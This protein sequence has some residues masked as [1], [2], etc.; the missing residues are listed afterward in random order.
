MTYISSP[1]LRT[2]TSSGNAVFKLQVDNTSGSGTTITDGTLW[3]KVASVSGGTFSSNGTV[4]IREGSINGSIVHSFT[5]F[6]GVSETNWSNYTL[7]FS[8]GSRTYY[9]TRNGSPTSQI[10]S[11]G[12]TVTASP[13]TATLSNI[14]TS[15]ASGPVGT[16]MTWSYTVSANQGGNVL[17]GAQL[18]S[19]GGTNYDIGTGYAKTL[20][21]G[22][23]SYSISISVPSGVPDGTYSL[24]GAVWRDNDSD[25]VINAGVDTILSGPSAYN[26]FTV[27]SPLTVTLSN[28]TTSPASGLPGTAMT[29]TYSVQSNQSK[30]VLLG[31][32]LQSSG[33]TNYDIGTGY[34]RS[35][36]SG[37][38]SPTVSLTVPAGIPAGTYSLR[39][40]VWNDNN[41]SGSID[42]GDTLLSGAFNYGSFTVTSPLTVTLSNI[43]TSPASGPV[44]TAMTW[45]YT[46]SANQG[47]NVLLGAQL[48][49][50]GGTNYD[51][52]TGYAKTLSAG[53]GSY[54][55]SI[56]VPSGVPDGTYSLRGAVW[57]DNDS[58][59]VINAGVDTILS[60][61]SAYNSF[62]VTSPPVITGFSG[63]MRSDGR[64]DFKYTATNANGIGYVAVYIMNSDQSVNP[65]FT[66]ASEVQYTTG[67]SSGAA[68]TL[69]P[70]SASQL[71]GWLT[72]GTLYR[73]RMKAQ[74][75][76]GSDSGWVYSTTFLYTE[77]ASAPVVQTPMVAAR[78]DGRLDVTTQAT[79]S[80]GL[81]YLAFYLVDASMA[82]NPAFSAASKIEETTGLTSGLSQIRQP[83]TAS[84]LA[85]WLTPGSQYRVRIKYQ[86]TRA[87]DSGWVYS[88][89]FTYAGTTNA[90]PTVASVTATVLLDGSLKVGFTATDDMTASLGIEVYL[91]MPGGAGDPGSYNLSSKVVLAAA[92]GTEKSYTYLPAEVTRLCS[93]GQ[94]HG[95]RVRAF[96]GSGAM[97]QGFSTVFAAPQSATTTKDV[98]SFPFGNRQNYTTVRDNDGWY[99]SQTFGTYNAGFGGYHLGEDWNLESGGNTDLGQPVFAIGDGTVVVA[100][101][102]TGWGNIVTIRHTLA[103]GLQVESFYAHLDRM[104]VAPGQV[105]SRGQQIGTVGDGGGTQEASHLH[106]ELRENTGSGWPAIGTGYSATARPAGWLDPGTFIRARLPGTTGVQYSLYRVSDTSG[107][108]H[109]SNPGQSRSL[110]T[111]GQVV[112]LTFLARN[113]GASTPTYALCNVRDGQTETT[114][115]RSPKNNE[116]GSDAAIGGGVAVSAATLLGAGQNMY[117]SFDVDT[118]ALSAGGYDVSGRLWGG[119]SGPS[120]DSTSEGIGDFL[121]DSW[122]KND[123]FI[124]TTGA[125]TSGDIQGVDVSR[126]NG[127]INW[128]QLAAEGVSFAYIR[129]SLGTNIPDT[130]YV[131]NAAGA[132]A[133]GIVHGA[134]HFAYPAINAA[135]AEASYF[136]RTARSQ[137]GA[138][139]LPPA[140]D[141]ENQSDVALT[142]SL[143][144]AALTDW[145]LAF[146]R[147]V[148]RQTGVKPIV[149][150]N[151]NFATNEV[152]SRV[153]E[154]PLWVADY[155]PN[156]GR[157]MLSRSPA[158]G[159]WPSWSL[160][161]FTSRATLTGN[162]ST[163][164][165]RNHFPGDQTAFMSFIGNSTVV[166]PPG[167]V[168][169]TPGSATLPGEALA[170]LTPRFTWGAAS[171]ATGYELTVIN[172]QANLEVYK[173]GTIG[174]TTTFDLPAGTLVQG[175]TYF[176]QMRARRG[177]LWSLSSAPLYFSTGGNVSPPVK[178]IL[179]SPTGATLPGS[180]VTSL[181]PTLTWKAQSTAMQHRLQI[182][183]TA[184]GESVFDNERLGNISSFQVPAGTL[185]EAKVYLWKVTA[186]NAAGWGP[187]SAPSYFTTPPGS[188]STPVPPVLLSPGS[189]RSPYPVLTSLTPTLTWQD[190]GFAESYAIIVND[191]D[192][193]ARAYED[194][195]LAPTTNLSLPAG[196]LLP[197]KT[198]HWSLRYRVGGL[199]STWAAA[200]H[201]QTKADLSAPAITSLPM[202][203]LIGSTASQSLTVLGT[204][205]QKGATVLL[206]N[207]TLSDQPLAPSKVV[208][209]DTT[210][211]TASL[212]TGTSADA[213]II[214]VRN[215]DGKVSN[216]ATFSVEAP[217][218]PL[219]AA[220]DIYPQ[221][222]K[223]SSPVLVTLSHPD[224]GVTL[225]YTTDGSVPQLSST[226][227][228]TP[229]LLGNTNV[230][231]RVRAFKDGARPSQASQVYTFDLPSQALNT[232]VIGKSAGSE[233]Y[234]F[235]IPIGSTTS[236]VNI[237]TSGGT[238][239]CSMYVGFNRLPTVTDYDRISPLNAGNEESITIQNPPLGKLYVMLI[240]SP[241]FSGL[242]VS[243]NGATTTSKA[244]KPRFNFDP[245]LHRAPIQNLLI[246]TDEANATIYYTI[247]SNAPDPTP[248]NATALA[249]GQS[250]PIFFTT[251]VRARSVVQGKQPSDLLDGTFIIINKGDPE[252]AFL[253][254]THSRKLA[255]SVE[256]E[257]DTPLGVADQLPFFFDVP[258]DGAFA[259]N[260]RIKFA[261]AMKMK[262][263]GQYTSAD[264]YFKRSTAPTTTD[265][266]YRLSGLSNEPLGL[267]KLNL[268]KV[269]PS[270]PGI[271]RETLVPGARYYGLLVAQGG[272]PKGGAIQLPSYKMKLKVELMQGELLTPQ[273]SD[274][275]AGKPNTWLAIH[276]RADE[277]SN[278][279]NTPVLRLAAALEY[280]P[281][282]VRS[283]VIMLDWNS[284][285]ADSYDLLQ[286]YKFLSAAVY[287]H[288][289]SSRV[290]DIFIANGMPPKTLSITGH[291]WGTFVAF[292]M[293]SPT[294]KLKRLIALDPAAAGQG[295]FK[296]S[297]VNFSSVAEKSWAFVANGARVS[298]AANPL[299]FI[300]DSVAEGLAGSPAKAATAREAFVIRDSDFTI[301]D[302]GSAYDYLI[303]MHSAPV[304]FFTHTLMRNYGLGTSS[305]VISDYF[306]I[307]KLDNQ[308]VKGDFPWLPN[309]MGSEIGLQQFEGEISA[310][311]EAANGIDTTQGMSLRYVPRGQSTDQTFLQQP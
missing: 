250:I 205:F 281:T 73:L 214:K 93:P 104:D 36:A 173:N 33:G 129:S 289:V 105:V 304:G 193:G 272:N 215:P 106:L 248:H 143:S 1:A 87:T 47:G 189:V 239:D 278:G 40:A 200:F 175:Q 32:A 163:Y 228:T 195:N 116:V 52:G 111:Q 243:V 178:T 99:A 69:Q 147:E 44:G 231:L 114:V 308:T 72:S 251:R 300:R 152:D 160:W 146:C 168:L 102:Y 141:V 230:T 292:K 7:P 101:S 246:N 169:K 71:S 161:Q 39:G 306:S 97:G 179:V 190:L 131:T 209:Q 211:L 277:V 153:S 192:T 259:G 275:Q 229:I 290:K 136:V 258:A 134:Y 120:L 265:Y 156:D 113:T 207:S 12:V 38:N 261:V 186:W 273:G 125:A 268:G 85:S 67:L 2:Y 122:W 140:L 255:G 112:R 91:S 174:N 302:F 287:I 142:S 144:S 221:G 305:D 90:A 232:T 238:G 37:S 196:R 4:E 299:E 263:E 65:A 288:A 240:G 50:S 191:S 84:S 108:P 282:T 66:M 151:R 284:M 187:A 79:D 16:A 49:S 59:G 269:N 109:S 181:T 241:P 118:S 210:R 11:G 14:T 311:I 138:G 188:I 76:L 171:T 137:I 123:R 55:I 20:S 148:Q 70:W 100:A 82:V 132:K 177:G 6:A 245:G 208:V 130:Q 274:L 75:A 256:F 3:F 295:G 286:S 78:A 279:G 166:P 285:S 30:T 198:Y 42:G 253:P 159:V 54:S 157:F 115:Y 15:P 24:R 74:N 267:T 213:W 162:G 89:P 225:H 83:W 199:W 296:D 227:F 234:Y 81:G 110:F 236:H 53:T 128:P 271:K 252:L 25:G 5:Y 204:S 254:T 194:S 103:D 18:R 45:S 244:V 51:I 291:S 98:F 23:G 29:W 8:S 31:A 117:F 217:T 303:S 41:S 88:D 80:D 43:T 96:D 9:A 61:P 309:K 298:Q 264:I 63:M 165:D 46:V 176:W 182:W 184:S 297:E 94:P 283:Q 164:I 301:S 249:A 202:T 95:V 223:R 27:T 247:D 183:E 242:Y 310:D 124:I 212:S 13:L 57:R 86:D 220:P 276:G 58:D 26:S 92:S 28:I 203:Q 201:F 222:G 19:S 158:A 237:A 235:T 21:A 56:S 68:Q 307:T 226:R 10:A 294:Q 135:L 64:L 149:Y 206:S 150:M 119:K 170:T 185:A 233:G 145:I 48:R 216:P 262:L 34:S 280:L 126:H 197:G 270:D 62:T 22:T 172:S 133:A 224:S 218:A 121:D 17:L 77:P 260:N 127:T 293:G 219:L 257:I 167:P 155:G 60:G 35:L 180:T 139:F 154:F 266:D 107:L